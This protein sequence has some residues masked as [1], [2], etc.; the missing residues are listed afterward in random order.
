[1]GLAVD[2]H[3]KAEVGAMAQWVWLPFGVKDYLETRWEAGFAQHPES[4]RPFGVLFILFSL[5]W[6]WQLFT[7]AWL[8]LCYV[9]FTSI[10]NERLLGCG[11]KCLSSQH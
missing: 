5:P 8:V 7:L 9:N 6:P 4:R 11:R 1:M 2:L 10:K 3:R